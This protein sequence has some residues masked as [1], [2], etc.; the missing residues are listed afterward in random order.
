MPALEVRG[1]TL[2]S[3]DSGSTFPV[4]IL[5]LDIGGANIKASDGLDRSI[6][7]PF[8]LWKQP[9][10]LAGGLGDV[11][12]S[13]PNVD[14]LA[15][16]MTGE[17]ADCFAT[18]A[19][20]VRRILEAVVEAASGK[21]IAV[22]QTGGEF[23]TVADALELIP[24]VA[25]ANWH[26]LATWVGRMVPEQSALLIDL[27]STTCDIIPLADG[28]PIPAAATDPGRLTSGELVY[29]GVRRTPLCALLDSVV[30]RGERVG[31]AAELFATTL[32]VF[33]LL[34]DIAEDAADGNTANGRGA[35]IA[36]AHDRLA[37]MVCA[38]RDEI[39]I[40]E[41]IDLARQYRASLTQRL[42]GSMR[43]VVARLQQAPGNIVIS[44]EGEFLLRDLIANSA[45][46]LEPKEPPCMGQP[47]VFSLGK[48]LG[49]THS[50]AA[51][52]F[53]LARLCSERL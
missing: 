53:A 4:R 45:D 28:Y 22:W 1:E 21:R 36:A 40:S 47:K 46:D 32:D 12:R 23:C 7:I 27:G 17:L 19:A 35:T 52:A 51:C 24:L 33:L 14:G 20:G 34:G 38:D 30:L 6:S 5:G 18:K 39:S 26:A 29:V 13:F 9:E 8:P 16:T 2:C 31:T 43:R 10:Q 48:M 41:A 25:A 3:L 15:V 42:T 49:A 44:G 50:Q 37:R 11:L